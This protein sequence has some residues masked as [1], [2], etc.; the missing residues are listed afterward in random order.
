MIDRL[1]GIVIAFLLDEHMISNDENEKAYYRYGVEITISSLLN[2]ILILGIGIVLSC[3]DKSVLFLLLFIPIRQFTG[4]YHAETYL[5]CNTCFCLSFLSVLATD[6]IFSNILTFQGTL[7][8]STACFAVILLFCPIE[9]PNK[10]IPIHKKKIHKVIAA[11]LAIAYGGTATFLVAINYS[12]G[13][14]VLYTLCLVTVL[15]ILSLLK[16]GQKHEKENE[17]QRSGDD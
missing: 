17:E 11:L 1:S 14:F 4:G 13:K 9:H 10:P 12:Y 8:I 7:Y 5:L 3:I 15:I 6:F 2:I 16:G